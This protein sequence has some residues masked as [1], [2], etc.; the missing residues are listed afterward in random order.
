MLD[1]LHARKVWVNAL[2]DALKAALS[3]GC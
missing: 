1:K 2:V 3:E